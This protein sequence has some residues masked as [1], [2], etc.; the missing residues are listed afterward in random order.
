MSGDARRAFRVLCALLTCAEA[1]IPGA[2]AGYVPAEYLN[3]I[4]ALLEITEISAG[5]RKPPRDEQVLRDF[6]N[7]LTDFAVGYSI[8]TEIRETVPGH[9]G[10]IAGLPASHGRP[11]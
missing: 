2:A 10:F 7:C 4:C 3:R 11:Q 1:A 8:A 6:N 5:A 9:D